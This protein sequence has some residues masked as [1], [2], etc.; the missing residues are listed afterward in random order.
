M[1][2]EA[3]LQLLEHIA[4]DYP[5]EEMNRAVYEHQLREVYYYFSPLRQNL[6]SWYDG[7]ENKRILEVGSEC[8]ALTSIMARQAETVTCL[9]VV[10][11][12]HRIN[13]T[14]NGKRDNIE[15]IE[16]SMDAL[17]A[18][19]RRFDVI[20]VLADWAQIGSFLEKPSADAQADFLRLADAM[21]NES[22][23]IIFAAENRLGTKYLAGAQEEYTGRYFGGLNGE[24]QNTDVQ[25]RSGAELD[26]M[27]DTTLPSY[28]VQRYYPYPDHHCPMM[29]YSDDYLPKKGELNLNGD[30]ALYSRLHLYNEDKV[31]DEL[32]VNG[33][34][35]AVSNSYFY[36]LQKGNKKTTGE[37]LLYTKFSNERAEQ[38]RIRTDIVSVDG[39]TMIRKVPQSEAAWQHLKNME[40]ACDKLTEDY[41][42][43][44]LMINPCISREKSMYF[45]FE[46]GHG[47]EEELDSLLERGEYNALD[48]RITAYFAVI[49]D[50]KQ[51]TAFELTEEFQTVFGDTEFVEAQWTR[52]VTD[53]DM[54]FANVICNE[55]QYHLIDYEWTFHFPIPVKYVIYRCLRYYILPSAK[56]HVLPL[57]EYYRRY[58]ISEVEE[59]QY[60]AM[61]EHFQAYITQGHYPMRQIVSNLTPG[62]LGMD[63]ILAE[64]ENQRMYLQIY[65]DEGNGYHE[66]DVTVLEYDEKTGRFTGDI[67]V[68]A[69][70]RN[71]R[72]D[73]F[74]STC[75]FVAEQ[76]LIDGKSVRFKTNCKKIRKNMYYSATVDPQIII[77]CRKEQAQLLHIEIAVERTGRLV[78]Q[79]IEKKDR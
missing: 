38:F 67:Q 55:N 22:G 61:E 2:I 44:T 27:I 58:H 78:S 32:I 11:E 46:E 4:A 75:I 77:D 36:I 49:C 45:P 62:N 65:W 8:G 10:S 35:S 3:D 5:E 19:G 59:Q 16:G 56:R 20:T 47:F 7:W 21:L 12:Y 70:I 6:I 41:M 73:P 63:S 40:Y 50:E 14:R 57:E 76:L 33:V 69:G 29:L 23:S 66:D 53:I 25:L 64:R 48:Q 52:S 31:W 24:L 43:T 51:L 9:E 71:I 74:S 42:G 37:Q 39:Q 1:R 60:A 26:K 15:Y 79:L 30:D 34:F 72:I 28:R 18:L 54:V 13:S 68:R 17:H